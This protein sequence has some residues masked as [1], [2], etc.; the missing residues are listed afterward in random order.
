MFDDTLLNDLKTKLGKHGFVKAENIFSKKIKNKLTNEALFQINKSQTNKISLRLS[1]QDSKF[2]KLI[3]SEELDYFF[4]KIFSKK[5]DL[6]T[7]SFLCMFSFN[8]TNKKIL[9]TESINKFHFDGY[10]YTVIL[11][12]N[13][14]NDDGIDTSL[15]IFPLLR[16][17]LS[18]FMFSNFVIKIFF[19]NILINKIINFMVRKEILNPVRIQLN[20]NEILIFNGYNSLHAGIDNIN[21]NTKCRLI[22]HIFEDQQISKFE[23]YLNDK[24]KNR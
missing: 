4:K 22:L 3:T 15:Y 2:I 14:D 16:S 5:F 1:K 12:I 11:P 13:L 21:Q 19:Q 10:L 23:K 20:Q 8:N 7:N 9:K 6:N 18:K 24:N 17:K